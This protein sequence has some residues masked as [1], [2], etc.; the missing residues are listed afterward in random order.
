MTYRSIGNF[1]MCVLAVTSRSQD[2]NAAEVSLAREKFGA[3]LT[4]LTDQSLDEVHADSLRNATI[5]TVASGEDRH[6]ATGDSVQLSNVLS[7][8]QNIR[9]QNKELSRQIA[10][11]ARP[12]TSSIKVGILAQMYGQALQE[13][14]SAAEDTSRSYTHHWQRQLFVRRL[15]ALF[16]GEIS[17]STSFFVESDAPNIGKVE[18]NGTKPTKVSMYVQ[19]AYIQETFMPELSLI[20]GLQLVGITRNS[21][22]SAASLMALDYGS[23]QFLTSTPFDNTAGRDVGLNLRGFLLDERLEYRAGLFSGK[24]LNL[25]S[26]LR[27][28]VRLNYMFEDR[29][30]GFFYTGTTLGKG[31]LFTVGGGLDLQ[32]SYRSYSLDAFGDLP[33]FQAGSITASG[34][35]T[36][37]NGGGSDADST[38]FTGAIPRQIVIFTEVGYFFKDYSFQPY[39]K[40]ESD[41]VNAVVLRQVNAIP[42]TLDLENKLRS[43]QRFGVGINY[44]FNGHNASAKI[45]YEFVSRWRNALAAGQLESITTGEATIQ[46]QVYAF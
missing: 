12:A 36:Y 24:N 31:E 38:F 33:L 32:G 37:L 29:E 17:N 45:L 26:P 2:L 3:N 10:P 39:L 13:Q 35:W 41:D 18:T 20:A 5:K 4:W 15:R 27:T 6:E 40:F 16:G 42:S 44:Y 9:E 28:V 8:L 21:L 7:E 11:L 19:D 30:K 22:Q 14:T 46:F 1:F 34:S 25:Y 43:K 23:Y